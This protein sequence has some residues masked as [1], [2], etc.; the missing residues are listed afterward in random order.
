MTNLFK[1]VSC[2]ESGRDLN[3]ASRF[4]QRIKSFELLNNIFKNGTNAHGQKHDKINK[5]IH[6]LKI[7]FT[8]FN[9][10]VKKQIYEKIQY[11]KSK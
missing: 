10:N 9:I 2:V 3:M 1:E 7:Q 8:T 4:R 6:L 11:H 5:K